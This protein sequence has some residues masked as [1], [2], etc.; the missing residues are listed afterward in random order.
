VVAR[1]RSPLPGDLV[2]PGLDVHTFE[3]Y[4]MARLFRAFDAAIAASGYNSFHEL[5]VGGVPSL[6]LPQPRETDD[7]ERRAEHAAAAGV[8]LV[9]PEL[10]DLPERVS[11]LLSD[12]VRASLRSRLDDHGV[13]NGADQAAAIVRDLV[14]T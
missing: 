3:A 14:G 9:A 10:V 11:A 8:G 7:Q 5:V 2:P 1:P 4:P 6:F 12:D 13:R